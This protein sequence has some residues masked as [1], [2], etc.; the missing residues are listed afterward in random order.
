MDKNTIIL[1]AFKKMYKY[2][3]VKNMKT[4]MHKWP[5]ILEDVK[6][7]IVTNMK[8]RLLKLLLLYLYVD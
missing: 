6:L 1:I 3:N 5:S 7:K 4:F 2:P 8:S